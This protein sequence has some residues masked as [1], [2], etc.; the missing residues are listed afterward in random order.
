MTEPPAGTVKPVTT[1]AK[2]GS[3]VGTP[4]PVMQVWRIGA[5]EFVTSVVAL[6][7]VVLAQTSIPL[8]VPVVLST[9]LLGVMVTSEALGL[10]IHP[11]GAFRLARVLL[12]VAVMTRVNGPHSLGTWIALGL[13]GSVIAAEG[14]YSRLDAIAVP[15]AVNLP[16]I[17]VRERRLVPASVIFY[18]NC[19]GVFVVS[20]LA[21]WDAHP[22]VDLIVVLVPA[23]ISLVG[24]VDCALR[25]QSRRMA[26]RRL[27]KV[28]ARYAPRF[29]VHWDAAAGTGYQISRWLPYLDRLG[30]RYVVIVRNPKS[31][32]EASVMTD[33]PVLLR[34]GATTLD[35][36]MVSSLVTVFYANNA[37]RNVHM[38][39]YP[40]IRHIMLNHGD[41]D[42]A[43]SYNPVTRMFDKNFVA[44]QAAVDRFAAHGVPT[45][46]DFFTIVGRPQVEDVRVVPGPVRK[47]QPRILYAPTWA[48]MHT[49]SAYSSLP[50]GPLLIRALIA[51]GCVI[52]YRP[53]PY[54]DR[55]AK[56]AAASAEIRTILETDARDS[57]RAHV[58]GQ[59][60]EKAWTIVDCFNE[61][62]ALISDVSSVV[63]DFLY[64]EKPFAICAMGGSVSEFYEEMPVAKAGY[65]VSADGANIEPVLDDLLGPDPKLSVRTELKTYY[66]GDIPADAYAEAFLSAAR[67]AIS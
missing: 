19:A 64:S 25:I 11:T 6:V 59:Q 55:N 13:L 35:A 24:L 9:L 33:H 46:P 61:A 21:L 27:P 54:S 10:V 38:V 40:G 36:I 52:I 44:G 12:L 56:L 65:V 37:L 62:D 8:V 57:D 50:I 43:P 63:P 60:A 4:I 3:R 41:S 31:F 58:W 20:I 1:T 48:G 26:E 29:A 45:A 30:E 66:L 39:R 42:K 28:L 51:R 23:A 15:Y 7:V 17:R 34:R 49:D 2:R 32:P 5:G 47:L 53:H 18:A 67:Q 16:E 14:V 22:V